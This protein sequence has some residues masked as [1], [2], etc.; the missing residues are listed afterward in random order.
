MQL[1]GLL[2]CSYTYQP[3]PSLQIYVFIEHFQPKSSGLGCRTA[4]L[5]VLLI[6]LHPIGVGGPA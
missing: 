6:H 4:V 1:L 3:F 5:V 2:V